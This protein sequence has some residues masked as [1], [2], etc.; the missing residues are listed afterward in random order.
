MSLPPIP[1][2]STEWVY[3]PVTSKEEPTG[4][5]TVDFAIPV[6]A[7]PDAGEWHAGEWYGTAVQIESGGD[8][9][10]IAR[11]QIGPGT[12][13]VLRARKAG[14]WLWGRVNAGSEAPVRRVCPLTIT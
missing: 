9:L 13:Y 7:E 11:V 2:T 14:W 8:W 12:D 5:E 10:S 3:V 4:S 6:G 1:A